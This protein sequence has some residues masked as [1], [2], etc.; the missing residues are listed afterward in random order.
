MRGP[1][2][3]ICMGMRDGKLTFE[4]KEIALDTQ[5]ITLGRS[6]DNTIAFPSDSNVSRYHA[7][8]EFRHGEYL[9]IDLG[10]SNGTT[11]NGQKITEASI[12]DGDTILLGGSSEIR[13][14]FG[15]HPSRETEDSLDSADDGGFSSGGS[16]GIPSFSGGEGVSMLGGIGGG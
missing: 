4:G 13:V 8:I 2:G 11:L 3:E 1:G 12:G 14:S 7:E 9:L 10:S 15:D 16:A 5:L 6:A